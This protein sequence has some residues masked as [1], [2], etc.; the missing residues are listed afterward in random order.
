MDRVKSFIDS[1]DL[2]DALV[3]NGYQPTYGGWYEKENVR[4]AF[5]DD[6]FKHIDV[7]K[8]DYVE[9]DLPISEVFYNENSECYA[10]EAI[11]LF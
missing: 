9:Y 2:C 10:T 4:V 11:K 5:R 6:S 1:R 8:E 7:E 3:D